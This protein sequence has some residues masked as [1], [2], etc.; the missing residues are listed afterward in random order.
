LRLNN[1]ESTR[2]GIGI[3]QNVERATNFTYLMARKCENGVGFGKNQIDDPSPL[4]KGFS[5]GGPLTG[6]ANYNTSA[7]RRLPRM[8]VFFSSLE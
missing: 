1:P 6:L 4:K 8:L 7:Q 2:S 5:A 3:V